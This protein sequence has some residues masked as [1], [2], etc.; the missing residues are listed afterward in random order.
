[1][2][3][4]L[5]SVVG[6]ALV[7]LAG[8]CGSGSTPSQSEPAAVEIASNASGPLVEVPDPTSGE[9]P[10]FRT[11]NTAAPSAGQSIADADLGTTQTRVVQAEGVRHEYSRF[12]PFNATRTMILLQDLASGERRVYRTSRAPY[13]QAAN[14]VRTIDLDEARWDPSAPNRLW[15]FRDFRIETLDVET[16]AVTLVKDFA[17]DPTIAPLL[18]QNPDLYRITMKDEGESS[19][20]KRYWAF[21]LQGSADD[22]RARF[23]FTWDRET[24]RVLGWRAISADQA[25]ID[26]AGMSRS[27]NW[28]LIGGSESNAAPLTG[29]VIANRELT[30]FQ[31]I[32]W[33]TA[34]SDVGLDDQGR[35][36]IVMQNVRTDYVDLIPLEAATRPI[37]ESGGSYQGT[38][39]TPLVRLNYADSP[40]GLSSGLHISC[41]VPGFC[42][43]STYIDADSPE[44]NW[45][46]RKIIVV[47]LNRARPRAFYLAKIYGSC[48]AYWEETHAAISSDGSRMVFATNWRQ[49]VGRERVWLMETPV[50]FAW[51]SSLK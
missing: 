12:D 46:D 8:S 1:M 31:R 43:I 24:D 25:D 35:D 21:L 14:A 49:N 5:H 38:N 7:V 26:W 6:L 48:E 17:R 22:Y 32:D 28:A 23:V 2:C 16:G 40:T 39:R 45:L 27:G 30:Q 3:P 10:V 33:A 19:H 50:P 36:V 51:L 4:P 11:S 44:R 9:N 18:A 29:L 42:V 34:H 20:D 15:G 41:N 37:L 47:K 13:D